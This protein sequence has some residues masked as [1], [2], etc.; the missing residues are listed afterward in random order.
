[1]LCSIATLPLVQYDAQMRTVTSPFL[2]QLERS[3]ANVVVLSDTVEDLL[4]E[5]FA[6][7]RITETYAD[8]YPAY[9]VRVAPSRVTETQEKD[10]NVLRIDGKVVPWDQMIRFDSPNPG[11]LQGAGGRT[12]RRALDLENT[13]SMYAD[14]PRPLDY[15]TPKVG[16]DPGDNEDIEATIEAWRAAR[17]ARGTAYVPGWLEYCT[18]DTPTPADLQLIE[19]QKQASV[20]IANLVGVDPRDLGVPINDETYLNGVDKRQNRVNDVLST[21]MAA[22]TERLSMAGVTKNGYTVEFD[23]NGYLRA[24]PKTRAEVQLMY[25]AQGVITLEEIR[26]EEKKGPLPTELT[27][28]P[29]IHAVVGQ[30]VPAIE[31]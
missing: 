3:R 16:D 25:L 31:A 17:R 8:G 26:M 13:S 6:Y 29:V 11:I 1:M 5:K 20:D 21:Y 4:F 19:Q 22:I 12:I 28:R 27:T 24:D 2:K 30:P 10:G 15:F 23:L 14:N 18:V 9:V 7:W